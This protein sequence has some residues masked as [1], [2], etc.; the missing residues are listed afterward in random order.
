MGL[1]ECYQFIRKKDY[2][3][4]ILN[5]TTIA[6]I[7]T[8]KRRVD[9]LGSSY[10]VL[11][12]VYSKNPQDRAHAL[13]L[14]ELSRF[15][16]TSTLV[17]YIDGPQAE[18]KADTFVVR[19]TAR[20]QAAAR[21]A[22]SLD[23]L[24]TQIQNNQHIRKRYFTD[25]RTNLSS[26]FYWSL[27]CRRE[28]VEFLRSAGWDA[29]L[30]PTEADMEIAKDFK[31]GDVVLSGDSDMLAYASITTLWRPISNGLF[32]EYKTADLL[33]A[34]AVSR[35]QLT[36]LAVV[37]KN[38]Y[39]KNIF[40][41]GLVFGW[42]LTVPFFYLDPRSIVSAYLTNRTVV[43]KNTD[44]KTFD[45]ALRVFVDLKQT[46]VDHDMS[47]AH[48][49]TYDELRERFSGISAMYDLLKKQHQLKGTGNGTPKDEIPTD[50]PDEPND[51]RSNKPK[52]KPRSRSTA[53]T[54]KLQVMRSMAYQHPTS[55]YIRTLSANI[56]RAVPNQPILQQE[57]ISCIQKAS[58]EAA[59]TTKRKGQA[60]IGAFIECLDCM[61]LGHL[62]DTD[63]EILDYFCPRLKIKHAKDRDNGTAKEE[64]DEEDDTDLE[65]TAKGV[66]DTEQLRFLWSFLICLYSAVQLTTELKGMYIKGSY[67]LHNK[68]TASREKGFLRPD[69]EIRIREDMSAVENFVLLNKMS[70]N[71]RKI[72]PITNSE[73]PFVGFS[74]RD[75]AGVFFKRGGQLRERLVELA[76]LDGICTSIVDSQTW[77]GWKES[78]YLIKQFI[79]DI[80][81]DNL[82]SRQKGRAGLLSS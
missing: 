42:V 31:E 10:R 65:G 55:L 13:M 75:L 19:D 57:V 64:D 22:T 38:D 43:S 48:C 74:E 17:F 56:R 39:G 68:L 81:P 29:R 66:K 28:L 52:P 54:E 36:A 78:G 45:S 15:G 32:L 26:S 79:A 76:S 14:K 71:S 3:P 16:S 67:E 23:T 1:S 21:C 2:S 62:S 11:R 30:R 34:L 33:L 51:N 60:L 24:E 50:K 9:V 27:P 61:G 41:S 47:S 72:A 12:N 4:T 46:P 59:T 37:S 35:A 82:T 49:L 63:R 73:Q 80:D 53:P 77:I 58:R 69:A 6:T 40:L 20:K 5:Q 70:Q 18:E 8:N 44:N 25:V 7:D